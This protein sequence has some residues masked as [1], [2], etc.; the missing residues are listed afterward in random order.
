LAKF[1]EEAGRCGEHPTNINKA[2]PV[3]NIETHAGPRV[4]HRSGLGLSPNQQIGYGCLVIVVVS[5][6]AMYCAGTFSIL[7]RQNLGQRAPTPTA[8]TRTVFDST[9]TKPPPTFINLPGGTLLATP[10]QAPI[11]TREFTHTPT[12]ELTGT[13]PITGTLLP[14]GSATRTPTRRTTG[15][16]TNTPRP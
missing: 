12:V 1:S 8:I 11:P 3:H 14:I 5:A 2:H 6:L 7:V 13:L 16:V 4:S 10:T 9:P 15:T